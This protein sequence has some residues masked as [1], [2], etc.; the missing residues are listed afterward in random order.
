MEKALTCDP[1]FLCPEASVVSLLRFM[2]SVMWRC[3]K[4]VSLDSFIITARQSTSVRLPGLQADASSQPTEIQY[5]ITS[6]S[7]SGHLST[8][9]VGFEFLEQGL[10]LDLPAV[11]ILSPNHWTTREFPSFSTLF[12]PYT[13]HHHL[14]SI[15]LT[16]YLL[17]SY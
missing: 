9:L 4:F 1:E 5:C 14:S 3:W 11:K 2:V 15:Y 8:W 6:C 17:L 12:F 10:N 16:Y 7:H 13:T